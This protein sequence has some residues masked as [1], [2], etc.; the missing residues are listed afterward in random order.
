M[1]ATLRQEGCR[2][3][4]RPRST[5]LAWATVGPHLRNIK[6]KT[7]HYHSKILCGCHSQKCL[8]G[9]E[10]NCRLVHSV[11]IPPHFSIRTQWQVNTSFI[12]CVFMFLQLLQQTL[13]VEKQRCSRWFG[14]EWCHLLI[15]FSACFHLETIW[16]G[17][18]VALLEEVYH[19][20]GFEVLEDVGHSQCAL[21]VPCLWIKMWALSCSSAMPSLC[22]HGF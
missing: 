17:T 7:H 3:L 14:W 11:L 21:S 18:V 19:G 12:F 13:V 2:G 4:P 9:K 5:K 20:V 8:F 10:G 1:L 6:N 15:G 16:E 22:H